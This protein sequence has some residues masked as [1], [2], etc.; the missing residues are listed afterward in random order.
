[1][2]G[3]KETMLH[4]EVC[5]YNHLVSHEEGIKRGMKKEIKA[6]E[7]RGNKGDINPVGFGN[8]L[9]KGQRGKLGNYSMGTWSFVSATNA[10]FEVASGGK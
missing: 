5:G 10:S 2:G 9:I 1:M 6:N 8:I 3:R 7:C 4:E